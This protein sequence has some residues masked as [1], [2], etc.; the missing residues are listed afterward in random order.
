[1]KIA[2]NLY[3]MRKLG[4][5]SYYEN[6]SFQLVSNLLSGALGGNCNKIL[7]SAKAGDFLH[8]HS[9]AVEG[10]E[11]TEYAIN[12]SEV[13]ERENVTEIF[14]D[15]TIKRRNNKGSNFSIFFSM[16]REFL[17]I[18][19]P[20]TVPEDEIDEDKK[21]QLSAVNGMLYNSIFNLNIRCVDKKGHQYPLGEGRG[22][23]IFDEIRKI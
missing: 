16:K 2:D 18:P 9:A 10:T 12:S 5:E 22:Y 6:N 4:T 20:F 23:L 7:V 13:I 3:K 14:V 19:K 17:V 1:M 21:G 8:D 11:T 15:G